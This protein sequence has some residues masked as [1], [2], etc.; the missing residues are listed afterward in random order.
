ME[1]LVDRT[2]TALRGN[3]DGLA[4]LVSGLTEDQ[5]SLTSGSS[6]WTVAQVLSHLGSGAEIALAGLR[7]TIA[8]DPV[9]APDFNQGVWD[10]WNARSPRAQAEGFVDADE[11]L[12][13]VCEALDADTRQ[14]LV[15]QLGFLPF[16]LPL[17]A[18]LGMRLN[19]AAQ[20]R[21]D[22]EVAFDPG[23]AV[24]GDASELV[25]EHFAGDIGF[26]LGFTGKADAVAG[27]A[28]ITVA[29]TGY[30]LLIEDTVTLTGSVPNPTGAF[31]GPIE[32]A[33]RLLAGRLDAEHTPAAV[34]VTGELT[35]DDLRRVFPGY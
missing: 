11:H 1:S 8:G 17:A 14:T 3:H 13:A 16:P 7:A 21:W 20:H 28:A 6:D 12:L 15:I 4:D 23:A 10:R 22:V 26:L 25:L 30:G 31:L 18:V 33:V 35:L 27:R 19:E 5:L 29:E 34:S 9:P 32:S 2:I 24:A